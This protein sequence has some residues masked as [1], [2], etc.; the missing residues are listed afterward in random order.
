MYTHIW[1]AA[2]SW[3]LA[4][5]LLLPLRCCWLLRCCSADCGFCCAAACAICMMCISRKTNRR[6]KEG[7]GNANVLRR[8][9]RK[10]LK[11]ENQA[12]CAPLYNVLRYGAIIRC[13]RFPSSAKRMEENWPCIWPFLIKNGHNVGGPFGQQHPIT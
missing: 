9:P 10:W 8:W 11:C 7:E 6:S 5:C 1:L 2:A 4:G 12:Y 13:T 3:L